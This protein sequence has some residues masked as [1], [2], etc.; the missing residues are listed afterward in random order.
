MKWT[1]LYC[2]SFALLI[3]CKDEELMP[4][5]QLINRSLLEQ[6]IWINQQEV[7]EQYTD[8]IDPI[9]YLKSSTFSFTATHYTHKIASSLQKNITKNIPELEHLDIWG[10][11][12]TSAIDSTIT[13]FYSRDLLSTENPNPSLADYTPLELKYK[14][15]KLTPNELTL[16]HIVDSTFTENQ[17]EITF[18]PSK[19]SVIKK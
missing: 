19:D 1:L 12:Q 6:S 2:L 9:K 3:G 7:E 16:K 4:S 8:Q 14:I 15:I 18:R 17:P 10:A 13:L 11:Y 5:E